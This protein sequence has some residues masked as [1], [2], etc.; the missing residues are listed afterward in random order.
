MDHV[1]TFSNVIYRNRTWLDN[2]VVIDSTVAFDNYI[3]SYF[4]S[5]YRNIVNPDLIYMNVSTIRREN[6]DASNLANENRVALKHPSNLYLCGVSEQVF[7]CLA[8]VC[9]GGGCGS[10]VATV[11]N[12][13]KKHNLPTSNAALLQV[14]PRHILTLDETTDTHSTWRT[15]RVFISSTFEVR[16]LLYCKAMQ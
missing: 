16:T 1:Y 9:N 10:Q 2:L 5:G 4:L 12:I 11:E 3:S 7:H 6:D 14:I 15:I 8:N 13:D